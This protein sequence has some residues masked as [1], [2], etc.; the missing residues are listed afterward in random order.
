MAYDCPMAQL[1]IPASLLPADGR[2][3]SGP[4]RVRAAQVQA[5]SQSPLLGTSHRAAPVKSLVGT[6]RAGLA[7]LFSLPAGYEVLLG[8]GGASAFWDAAA[9]GLVEH[10][11]QNLSFGSFG[12]K[13]AAACRAPWLATPDIR[14][15]DPGSRIDPEPVEGVDVYAWPQNETSTGVMAPVRRVVADP[16]AL[17]VID[18]T[19]AAGGLPVQAAEFDVYYF[20]PQKNFGADGGLWV[21]AVSP[22]AIERIERIAAGDRYIPSFLSLKQALDNS[23]KNQTLN[24]PAIATLV[25]LQEQISWM[26]EH[27]GLSWA[28]QRTTASS[29]LLYEWA[30]RHASV[31]PFVQDPANRSSVVV[32]LEL[33]RGLQEDTITRILTENGIVNTGSYRK[34]GRNQ[35]RIGTFTSVSPEDV[36]SLIACLDYVFERV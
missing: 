13:F 7:E 33:L 4:S 31:A 16:G 36:A 6:I 22:A 9:A 28:A 15:A 23:R 29:A 30:D 21:A 11:S 25:L 32:T 3:G 12:G 19:S 35:L 10:R 34:L 24:T 1:T 5:L 8:V 26:L 17:T 14:T 18:A 27:G 20:S 2:F